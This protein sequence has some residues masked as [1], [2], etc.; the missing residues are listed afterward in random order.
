M[1]LSLTLMPRV[2]HALTFASDDS[3]MDEGGILHIVQI[4]TQN[5]I[6]CKFA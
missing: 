4:A 1:K 3:G 6:N 5:L 2:N